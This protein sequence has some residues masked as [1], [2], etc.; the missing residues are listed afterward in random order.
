MKILAFFFAASSAQ[1]CFRSV[2][3]TKYLTLRKFKSSCIDNTD[4]AVT[5]RHLD[6]HAI[7][8]LPKSVQ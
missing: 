4:E 3:N 2:F 8:E 6:P 7:A 1:I 5:R